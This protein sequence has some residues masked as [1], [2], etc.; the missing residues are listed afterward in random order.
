MKYSS[1]IQYPEIRHLIFSS[2]LRPATIQGPVTFRLLS[3]NFCTY[4]R[5]FYF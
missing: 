1:V 2:V 3:E 5:H 4:L